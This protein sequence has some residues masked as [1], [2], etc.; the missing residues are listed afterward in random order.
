M[1]TRGEDGRPH[2]GE[3]PRGAALPRPDLG[4]RD[5]GT[6]HSCGLSCPARWPLWRLRGLTPGRS[7]LSL[8]WSES[9][10]QR[11]SISASKANVII[12]L[13]HLVS[14]DRA[15]PPSRS[16]LGLEPHAAAWVAPGREPPGFGA[17]QMRLQSGGRNPLPWSCGRPA[18][19]LGGGRRRPA[20]RGGEIRRCVWVPG[21]GRCWAGL[22]AVGSGVTVAVI[23]RGDAG[24]GPPAGPEARSPP[25]ASG[26]GKHLAPACSCLSNLTLPTRAALLKPVSLQTQ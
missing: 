24:L 21:E 1:R 19:S 16:F 8:L 4:P 18:S 3:G 20:A 17:K 25:G 15:V 23:V 7:Q 12:Y 14:S 5:G 11:C 22:C 26:T 2:T 6:V 10:R 13:S 9:C